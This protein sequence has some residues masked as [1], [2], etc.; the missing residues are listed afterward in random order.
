[1]KTNQTILKLLFATLFFAFTNFLE[2]QHNNFAL[3][4]YFLDVE[5]TSSVPIISSSNLNSSNAYVCGNSFYDEYDHLMFYVNGT[6]VYDGQHNQINTLLHYYNGTVFDKIGREVAIVPIPG[7]CLKWYIIYTMTEEHNYGSQLLYMVLDCTGPPVL[8]DPN[9]EYNPDQGNG[10]AVDFTKGT[11]LA[12]SLK[13]PSGE[14][15]LF[16]GGREEM[17]R[18]TITATS[19]GNVTNIA[20]IGTHPDIFAVLSDFH[21]ELELSPNQQFLAYRRHEYGGSDNG[22]SII[23]LKNDYNYNDSWLLPFNDGIVEGLEFNSTSDELYFSYNDPTQNNVGGLGVF[24]SVTNINAPDNISLEYQ[25]GNTFLE[26]GKNGYIYGITDDVDAGLFSMNI[27]G[28]TTNVVYGPTGINNI[29][30]N[31]PVFQMSTYSM[32]DQIDGENYTTLSGVEIGYVDFEIQGNQQ[33]I[34]TYF[35]CPNEQIPLD[36]LSDPVI[37]EYQI[38]VYNSNSSG[39]QLSLYTSNSFNPNFPG[40]LA[41]F[42]PIPNNQYYLVTI[43]GRNACGHIESKT[44]LFYHGKKPS[45]FASFRINNSNQGTSPATS[46]TLYN[47]S[48]FAATI[49]NLSINGYFYRFT[50]HQ[51]PT[52]TGTYSTLI[53]NTGWQT[54]CGTNLYSL[55]GLP[56]GTYLANNSGYFLITLYVQNECGLGSSYYQRY[57]NITGSPQTVGFE[58]IAEVI[59]GETY[60]LNGCTMAAGQS[61]RYHVGPQVCG[62]GGSYLFPMETANA[63]SPNEVGRT[64]TVFDISAINAS[65]GTVNNSIEIFVDQWN[66]SSFVPYNTNPTQGDQIL[67]ATQVPLTSLLQDPSQSSATQLAFMNPV[68]TPHGSIWRIRI[69]YQNACGT[70]SNQ[71]IIQMNTVSLKSSENVNTGYDGSQ[72]NDEIQYKMYPN[73]SSSIINF[74]F[75]RSENEVVSITIHDITGRKVADVKVD[76]NS[77]D[78]HLFK[79]DIHHL[80]S[81]TY[82]YT[83]QSSWGAKTA[84]FFKQ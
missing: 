1:M 33:G 37:L 40:N 19:I 22:I 44:I 17:N 27:S 2:A 82:Y 50:V 57:V 9:G 34:Y 6:M 28:G 47:C 38:S 39:S 69:E 24:S 13:Q 31:E 61:F 16:Y 35:S 10:Q 83:I 76:E 42:L 77:N 45:A 46:Q 70:V 60:T 25:Y 8:S 48:N 54:F 81:G 56:N 36:N 74:E 5:N 65:A 53:H 72:L 64:A 4:P 71:Q 52:L 80:V 18:A 68:L 32:N 84:T 3:P 11:G 12:V 51:S 30:S 43:S 63:S 59:P 78:Q 73:P 14:R 7:E 15:Y 21:S 58:T 75:E 20:S 79:A 67:S 23:E 55:P 26:M 41:N 49:Q 66:G 62:A 29:Y